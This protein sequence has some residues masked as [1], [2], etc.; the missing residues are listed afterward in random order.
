M[1]ITRR[2]QLRERSTM[3]ITRREL[4]REG[5]TRCQ[6][7]REG[8]TIRIIRRPVLR[9]GRAASFLPPPPATIPYSDSVGAD[10]QTIDL[11]RA[12]FTPV[13]PSF[14]A[15]RSFINRSPVRLFLSTYPRMEQLKVDSATLIMS[16]APSY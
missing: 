13:N 1:R 7:L 5:F 14:L 8:S 11:K 3:Q 9:V 12:P 6:Q 16:Q 15:D 4:L 10:I 2:Q